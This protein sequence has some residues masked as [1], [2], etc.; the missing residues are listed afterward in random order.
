MTSRMTHNPHDWY[1]SYNMLGLVGS[2][3]CRIYP[4]ACRCGA[5]KKADGTIVEPVRGQLVGE[6]SG[7]NNH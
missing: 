1:G 3:Y 7:Q 4:W 6:G 5:L 2:L